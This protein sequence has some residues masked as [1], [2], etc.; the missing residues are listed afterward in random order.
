MQIPGIWSLKEGPPPEN[1]GKWQLEVEKDLATVLGP[2]QTETKTFSRMVN[3]DVAE[4]HLSLAFSPSRVFEE[5]KL[6]E[7][8]DPFVFLYSEKIN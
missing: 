5:H 2:G 7:G 4:I 8:N 6:S 1:D 3:F